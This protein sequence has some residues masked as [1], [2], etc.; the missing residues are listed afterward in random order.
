MSTSQIVIFFCFLVLQSPG[1]FGSQFNVETSYDKEKDVT[2]VRSTSV[3]LSGEKDRYHSLDFSLHFSYPG[4]VR[5][6]PERINFDLMSVVKGRR[7]NTDLYVVFLLDGKP[8]HFSSNR[9]AI[10]NPVPGRLWVGE[11]LV[12]LIPCEDFLKMMAAEKLTIKMGD[13]MFDVKDEAR[14]SLRAFAKALKD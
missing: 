3:R 5:R 4:Q 10:R 9:S 1:Q 11:R 14:E 12:F 8:A 6:I 7:L 13:V 2:T